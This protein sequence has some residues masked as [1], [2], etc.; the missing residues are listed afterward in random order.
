[1]VIEDSSSAE[2]KARTE[3]SKA[4]ETI[5]AKSNTTSEPSKKSSK[6]HKE[7][8]GL[9][10]KETIIREAVVYKRDAD[11]K[12]TFEASTPETIR[13]TRSSKLSPQEAQIRRVSNSDESISS[14][15]VSYDGQR[16]RTLHKAP[17]HDE[18]EH[19]C[20]IQS[21][22]TKK[23][24]AKISDNSSDV[25]R[26]QVRSRSH[27]GEPDIAL[28]QLTQQCDIDK[29]IA[30]HPNAWSHGRMV[31]VNDRPAQPEQTRPPQKKQQQVPTK[32]RHPSPSD[33]SWYYAKRVVKRVG[34]VDSASGFTEQSQLNLP[35]ERGRQ[36]PVYRSPPPPLR[37]RRSPSDESSPP[38]R[39]SQSTQRHGALPQP[40]AEDSTVYSDSMPPQRKRSILS[41]RN[42]PPPPPAPREYYQAERARRD[43]EAIGD[44]L[45]DADVPPK[46]HFAASSEAVQA[47]RR[48]REAVRDRRE[49]NRDQ[50]EF[51]DTKHRVEDNVIKK[52]AGALEVDGAFSDNEEDVEGDGDDRNSGK[53]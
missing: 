16:G 28:A 18:C 22:K 42:R 2:E 49:A 38:I 43:R 15:H 11:G 36:R 32:E 30:S 25:T 4:K 35:R 20:K 50:R 27:H 23:M 53:R 41:Q 17:P 45:S 12:W 13:V 3:K 14:V 19:D 1:M 26:Y 5:E 44:P 29:R 46:V 34:K 31:I 51:E 7:I 33:H 48:E 39:R 6:K 40:P 52:G 21:V 9:D 10:R 37:R 24:P 47:L 8:K